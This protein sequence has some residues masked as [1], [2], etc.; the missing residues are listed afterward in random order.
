MLLQANLW[1]SLEAPHFFTEFLRSHSDLAFETQPLRPPLSGSHH[2]CRCQKYPEKPLRS[3]G[4][5]PRVFKR[6]AFGGDR[7]WLS[8]CRHQWTGCPPYR[9]QQNAECHS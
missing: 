9:P 8:H 4:N 1:L 5:T 3:G 2:G 6:K 7:Q